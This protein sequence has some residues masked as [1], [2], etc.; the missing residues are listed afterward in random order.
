MVAS[1]RDYANLAKFQPLVDVRW[2]CWLC[3]R[4]LNRYAYFPCRGHRR[5]EPVATPNRT[6][7]HGVPQLLLFESLAFKDRSRTWRDDEWYAWRARVMRE[8]AA[9]AERRF[10]SALL[11]A[12][13]LGPRR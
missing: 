11:S 12:V 8:A 7:A 5:A 2:Y 4:P 10:T 3:Q 6:T 1:R 13:G 9:E